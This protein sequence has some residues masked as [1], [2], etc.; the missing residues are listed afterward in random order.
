MSQE[1]EDLQSQSHINHVAYQQKI[2]AAA[3]I[4]EEKQQT[5]KYLG[6]DA[7]IGVGKLK[8]TNGSIIYAIAQTNGAIAIG[9]TIRLRRG[10]VLSGYDAMPMPRVRSRERL[11]TDKAK[12][13]LIITLFR[14]ENSELLFYIGGNAPPK[15]ITELEVPANI[16]FA[17]NLGSQ[18]YLVTIKYIKDGIR[19]YFFKDKNSEAIIFSNFISGDEYF[20]GNGLWESNSSSSTR[21]TIVNKTK[22]TNPVSLNNTTLFD[23]YSRALSLSKVYAY[24]DTWTPDNPHNRFLFTRDKGTITYNDPVLETPGS[25]EIPATDA[26]DVN[27]YIAYTSTS[28]FRHSVYPSRG[29]TVYYLYIDNTYNYSFGDFFTGD[30]GER[31]ITCT[32]EH[33]YSIPEIQTDGSFIQGSNVSDTTSCVL[34]LYYENGT[35]FPYQYHGFALK[36]FSGTYIQTPDQVANAGTLLILRV[37]EHE[38]DITISNIDFT[39]SIDPNDIYQATGAIAT[40]YDHTV[41]AVPAV[42]ATPPTYYPPTIKEENYTENY[43]GSFLIQKTVDGYIK[44]QLDVVKTIS[45]KHS[46][47]TTNIKETFTR[48]TNNLTLSYDDQ[49]IAL[50]LS[51]FLVIYTWNL[52]SPINS[53]STVFELTSSTQSENKIDVSSHVGNQFLFNTEVVYDGESVLSLIRGTI[54]SANYSNGSLQ[55]RCSVSGISKD[56]TTSFVGKLIIDNGSF[57]AYILRRESKQGFINKTVLPLPIFNPLPSTF[58]LP[59]TEV[60]E[61]FKTDN[62]VRSNIYSVAEVG[63]SIAYVETWEISDDGK[64]EFIKIARIPYYETPEQSVIKSHSYHP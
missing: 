32:I 53:D 18:N 9:D 63:T 33:N 23:D 58:S 39:S 11:T 21:V 50:D 40:K 3:E 13:Y 48:L 51:D 5:T 22:Y 27:V 38:S 28:H 44:Q 34:Q 20:L 31:L 7:E 14:L 59:F 49:Q 15:Q 29:D 55:I 10:G 64:I 8:D 36:V 43:S 12:K 26:Y 41:P 62:V 52:L 60:A 25:P 46:T 6:F 57:Y 42:P 35:T 24:A 45:I 56:T 2:I 30:S 1:V 4:S 16:G 17:T 47:S 54:I 37:Y 19:T 61:I